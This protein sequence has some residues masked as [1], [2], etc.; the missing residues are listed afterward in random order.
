MSCNVV[1]LD[2][3]IRLC[4]TNE[5]ARDADGGFGIKDWEMKLVPIAAD[6]A[7]AARKSR[8][9]MSKIA[10]IVASSLL[11]PILSSL[12]HEIMPVTSMK[13]HAAQAPRVRPIIS[14]KKYSDKYHNIVGYYGIAG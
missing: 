7:D 5:N 13:R 9:M 3:A 4:L 6:V 2:I 11:T 12:L 10:F 8:V 14:T 1:V